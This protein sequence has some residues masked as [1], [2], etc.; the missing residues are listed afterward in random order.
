MVTVLV[1]LAGS[2]IQ[3]GNSAWLKYKANFVT[4]F[5]P[6]IKFP[7]NFPVQLT[8]AE[9]SG[10]SIGVD[11]AASGRTGMM[12]REGSKAEASD[13]YGTSTEGGTQLPACWFRF[14]ELRRY[15]RSLSAEYGVR[16]SI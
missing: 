10:T 13:G 7:L 16:E 4:A 11:F 3:P 1:V 2:C 12:A 9:E 14:P 5:D 15:K 6:G 8:I